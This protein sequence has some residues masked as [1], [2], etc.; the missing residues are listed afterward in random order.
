ML[1]T[2]L[3]GFLLQAGIAASPTPDVDILAINPEIER[4]LEERVR[5]SAP[6]LDRL[7]QL[8]D[9]VFS[10]DGLALAYESHKTRT[11]IETFNDRRGDCLSFTNLFVAM[12]RH[13]GLRVFFQEVSVPATWDK[14]GGLMVLNRHVNAAVLIG[15]RAYIVDFNPDL[16]RSIPVRLLS[17]AT[18][19]AQY[20]SN[21]GV[22][23][24]SAKDLPKSLALLRKA[25]SID[26][27]IAYA[28]SN[29]GVAYSRLERYEEAESAYKN[30]L[31]IED[32]SLT[33]MVNLASLY[34]RTQR[35]K[36]AQ[37][38]LKKVQRYREKNPFYHYSLGESA[39][40]AGRFEEAIK[41]FRDAIKR[42]SKQHEFYFALAKA[43]TRLGRYD[44]AEKNL[45][46]ARKWAEESNSDAAW[47]YSQKLQT[48]ARN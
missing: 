2:L 30:A 9:V 7:N 39:Y 37:K 10:D 15:A 35:P 17:D 46:K 41:H 18:A 34:H 47:R 44:R 38:F 25:V 36:K 11:A 42:K 27:D 40:D 31:R 29:L 45:K 1:T 22:E 33:A 32:D 6:P 43:Y 14:R 21:K 48:L 3:A 26:P 13:L 20:Y 5:L 12:A 24:L 19:R 4:Y 28:W 8:M 16:D 23:A